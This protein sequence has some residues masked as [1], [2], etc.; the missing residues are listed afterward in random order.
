MGS[1]NKVIIIG[2]LTKDPIIRT[3]D[4]GGKIALFD[5]AINEKYYDKK[6]NEKKEKAQ[7][8]KVRINKPSLINFVENYLKKGNL[9][10]VEGRL[11]TKSYKD[12]FDK[13]SYITE[14]V[15]QSFDHN[16]QILNGGKSERQKDTKYIEK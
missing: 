8:C 2:R 3:F 4:N 5:V 9:T 6:T 15:L 7:F 14:I 10:Y 16:L 12:K 13:T 11:E 1:I